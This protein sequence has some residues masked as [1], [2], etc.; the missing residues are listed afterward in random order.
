MPQTMRLQAAY[1]DELCGDVHRLIAAEQGSD[2]RAT[3]HI[4]N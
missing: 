1:F 3:D 4:T 2:V